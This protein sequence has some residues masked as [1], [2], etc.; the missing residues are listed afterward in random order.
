MG[1][2]VVVGTGFSGAVIARQIAEK[3]NRPVTILEKR[4][5]IAGNM[6]DEMDNHEILV[7]KYGPHVIVTNY[8]LVIEFLSQYSELFKHTVKELSFID[9]KYVRLPFNFES[10]QQLVGPQKAQV[11]IGKLRK[12]YCGRDRV[13]VLELT[14]SLDTEISDFGTLLFEKSYRTYCAK[15]WGIPVETLDATIMDRVPMAMSYDERYMD[16][17]FQ[18]LP[19]HGFTKLFKNLLDHPNIS[20]SLNDDAMEH[21]AFDNK[22]KSVMFDGERLDLL[23]YTGA[24]DE[25]FDIKYGELPYRS[26]DI[27][28]EWLD[29]ERVFPEKIIS[30]PQADGYTRKTEY[31]FM[32]YDNSFSKGSVI[33]TE[34]PTEYVKNRNMTPFYPVITDETKYRYQLY[35][36]E[37]ESF[38]NVFLCGRLADFKYYNMDDCILHAFEVFGEIENYMKK[39]GR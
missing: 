6:Y 34:Y 35:R 31:K 21:I 22:T 20:I 25:L 7:Q 18:Y 29:Q 1:K 10:V 9:G 27:Q 32:M 38:E 14:K 36:N 12:T 15:Q 11:I 28:N 16:R 13:P 30:F 23:V 4:G 37:A 19:K 2:I 26:L 24:V 3:L 39:I 17:D 8:W 5:H 33:A